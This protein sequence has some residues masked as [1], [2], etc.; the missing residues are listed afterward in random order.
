MAA[1]VKF[2]SI[3]V[4]VFIAG[5]ITVTKFCSKEEDNLLVRHFSVDALIYS[6]YE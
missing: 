3:R 6:V 5:L 1:W 4:C 2:P